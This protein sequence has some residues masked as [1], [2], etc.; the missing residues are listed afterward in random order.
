MNT[1]DLKDLEELEPNFNYPLPIKFYRVFSDID[2]IKRDIHIRLFASLMFFVLFVALYDNWWFIITMSWFLCVPMFW[3]YFCVFREMDLKE[4]TPTL[5]FNIDDNDIQLYNHDGKLLIDDKKSNYQK[6]RFDKFM[7]IYWL[8]I[9]IKDKSY[10]HFLFDSKACHY[11]VDIDNEKYK[12]RKED[13]AFFIKFC[14]KHQD[15]A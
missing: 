15:N 1:D 10:R 7:G 3:F 5:I 11:Y 14:I 6:S 12:L 4:N 2:V 8:S 13:L 9:R